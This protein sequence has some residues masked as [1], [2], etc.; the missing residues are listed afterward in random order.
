MNRTKIDP[1]VVVEHSFGE[2]GL[3]SFDLRMGMAWDYQN[4]QHDVLVPVTPL[5][6]PCR[7]LVALLLS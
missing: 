2:S 3:P 7:Y 4:Q 6:T 1:W 5:K